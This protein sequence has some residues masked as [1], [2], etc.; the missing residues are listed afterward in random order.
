[1]QR[2]FRIAPGSIILVLDF[3]AESINLAFC[4]KMDL[5]EV[6]FK[7]EFMKLVYSIN[8]IKTR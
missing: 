2:I 7:K 6:G 4:R 3:E 8:L 1:M 5:L